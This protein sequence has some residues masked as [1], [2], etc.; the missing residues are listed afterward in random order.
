M[1]RFYL[2]GLQQFL[3]GCLF[4][5]DYLLQ[6]LMLMQQEHC[7]LLFYYRLSYIGFRFGPGNKGK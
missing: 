7:C 1:G 4:P 6:S 5:Q 3:S 2:S